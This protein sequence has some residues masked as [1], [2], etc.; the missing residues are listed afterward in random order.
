MSSTLRDA[1][2]PVAPDPDAHALRP[3]AV[4]AVPATKVPDGDLGTVVG[5]EALARWK[6]PDKR[7]LPAAASR[8]CSKAALKS[9][10]RLAPGW[11]MG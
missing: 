5:A 8:R 7:V 4:R 9:K 11:W 2:P 10:W 6:H 3:G 1:S